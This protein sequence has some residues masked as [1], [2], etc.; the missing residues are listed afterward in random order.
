MQG[1]QTFPGEYSSSVTAASNVSFTSST[2]LAEAKADKYRVGRTT[3]FTTDLLPALAVAGDALIRIQAHRGALATLV[4]RASDDCEAAA[5]SIP[6]GGTAAAAPCL[7]C[8][9]CRAQGHQI[10]CPRPSGPTRA[11]RDAWPVTVCRYGDHL[12][13]A[14]SVAPHH[15]RHPHTGACSAAIGYLGQDTP[16]LLPL[17]ARDVLV[18]NVSKAAVR[19]HATSPPLPPSRTTRTR[20]FGSCPPRPCTRR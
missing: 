2:P 9:C 13:R 1:H 18:V 4:M 19:A 3:S 16:A 10:S 15:P 17:R 20:V 14:E 7:R 12:P 11:L 6:N 5:R 8:L